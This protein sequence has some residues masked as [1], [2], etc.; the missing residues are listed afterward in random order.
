VA[1]ELKTLP[2]KATRFNPVDMALFLSALRLAWRAQRVRQV[3]V[4]DVVEA[5]SLRGGG[6]WGFPVERLELA[7]ARAVTRWR[8]WFGGIDTCLTRSLVLGG[9][10]AGRGEVM[11]NI[12]FRPGEEE[13]ALDGHAWVTV[14]G[15]PLGA[16][17]DLAGER[18]TR[19][20]TEPFS[21]ASGEE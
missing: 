8:R 1:E 3:P 2:H 9:L 10:L 20:L 4:P 15:N 5:I 7:A 12:G 6:G 14:D 21:R 16:D 13:P 11:L 19:V 17:G 18:Y